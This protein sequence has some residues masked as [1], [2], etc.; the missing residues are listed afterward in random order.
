MARKAGPKHGPGDHY[1]KYSNLNF[2]IVASM[3]ERVTGER[4]DR[5]MR[6]EVIEPMKLDACYNW[7]TCSDWKI[8]HAVVLTQDGKAIK[9][10][11]GGSRPDCPVL[12]VNMARDGT[13][14]NKQCADCVEVRAVSRGERWFCE[15]H[16]HEHLGPTTLLDLNGGPSV[17]GGPMW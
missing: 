8:A 9:D 13:L 7:P 15:R 3:I 6:R 1:F 5:W 16:H 12:V 2:P 10:D 4:F 14:A 17:R 11:L